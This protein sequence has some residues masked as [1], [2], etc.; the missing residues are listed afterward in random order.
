MNNYKTE[1]FWQHKNKETQDNRPASSGYGTQMTCRYMQACIIWQMTATELALSI[2]I[3]TKL[4]PK[5]HTFEIPCGFVFLN[6]E[7]VSSSRLLIQV[8]I[9]G[10]TY[11]DALLN[12]S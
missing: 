5:W 7:K 12:Y 1:R 9:T 6:T 2:L 11:C 4:K 3:H 10:F 8:D